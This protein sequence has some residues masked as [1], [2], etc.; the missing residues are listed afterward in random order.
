MKATPEELAA[1]SQ[2]MGELKDIVQDLWGIPDCEKCGAT[3][4]C[5]IYNIFGLESI[6]AGNPDVQGCSNYVP[7]KEDLDDN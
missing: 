1:H 4:S 3:E 2:V 5:D 6:K 7:L